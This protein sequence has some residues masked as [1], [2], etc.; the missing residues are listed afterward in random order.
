VETGVLEKEARRLTRGHVLRVTEQRPEIELKL[1]V[2]ADGLIAPGD[3][4]PVWVTG[5]QARARAHL[6]RAR[7]DAVLVGRG[8]VEAD[9]PE[10]TCRLPGME[11]LS[12]V[13]VVLDSR[14][15]MPETAKLL[16]GG[17]EAPVWV[18][19]VPDAPEAR[20]HAL[21]AAGAKIIP[22]DAGGDGRPEPGA[23]AAALAGRGITRLLIEGGPSIAR[24][25]LDAGII[26]RITI[27]RGE[28]PVGDGL[29][30]FLNDGLDVIEK[31]DDF[32]VSEP[33]PVGRDMMSVYEK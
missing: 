10:L 23:V 20:K 9:D 6:M 25:F 30:P 7:A 4:A 18:C 22:V 5:Q 8:T 12:P 27:F 16:R 32:Y 33:L 1:A 19:C 21:E 28:S 17:A 11:A 15:E 2:G 26:D 13:R 3:G 14:L 29:N 24:S 31:K